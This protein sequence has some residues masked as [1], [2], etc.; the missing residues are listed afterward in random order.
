MESET[1]DIVGSGCN[2]GGLI[3]ISCKMSYDICV[4]SEGLSFSGKE[5]RKR[6]LEWIDLTETQNHTLDHLL[7]GMEKKEEGDG[8]HHRT[9]K[10]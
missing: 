1:V 5:K 7:A 8:C 3:N 6:G 10:G 9:G 2:Q 4:L